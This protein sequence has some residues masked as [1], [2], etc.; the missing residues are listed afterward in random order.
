MEHAQGRSYL[1]KA[2]TWYFISSG[3][4]AIV[5]ILGFIIDGFVLLWIVYNG[6]DRHLV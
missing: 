4:A 1:R 2:G 6:S 5:A 3:M